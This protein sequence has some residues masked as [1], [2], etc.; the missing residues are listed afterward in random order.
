[1]NLQVITLLNIEV[2]PIFQLLNAGRV[3]QETLPLPKGFETPTIPEEKRGKG[4][5]FSPF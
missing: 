2:Q 4:F 3:L 1:M 5:L